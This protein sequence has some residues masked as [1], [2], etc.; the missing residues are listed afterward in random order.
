MY[1]YVTR[2]RTCRLE[3][4]RIVFVVVGSPQPVDKRA[5]G[6]TGWHHHVPKLGG[7]LERRVIAGYRDDRDGGHR[8]QRGGGSGPRAHLLQ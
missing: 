6:C 8:Q 4:Q 2:A 1:L 7:A 5:D 3:I